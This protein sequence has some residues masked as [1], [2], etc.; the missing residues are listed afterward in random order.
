[1]FVSRLKMRSEFGSICVEE[2]W[3]GKR[4][5]T[6]CG[7]DRVQRGENSLVSLGLFPVR[8]DSLLQLADKGFILLLAW[9]TNGTRVWCLEWGGREEGSGR[10][11]NLQ[12]EARKIVLSGIEVEDARACCFGTTVDRLVLLG[13]LMIQS[14]LGSYL[15]C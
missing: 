13:P 10:R 6:I 9:R 15:A 12:A 4:S 7:G 5:M 1:M 8:V 14:I 11:Q 2:R 3:G